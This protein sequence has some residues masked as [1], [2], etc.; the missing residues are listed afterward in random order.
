MDSGGGGADR[1]RIDGRG[2]GRSEKPAAP[3]ALEEGERR[4]PGAVEFFSRISR[5]R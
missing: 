2:A 3:A 4:G 1:R 5:T